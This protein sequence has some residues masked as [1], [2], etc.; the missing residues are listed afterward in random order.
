MIRL[1]KLRYYILAFAG[2]VSQFI[3]NLLNPQKSWDSSA[4]K[5]LIF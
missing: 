5:V 1:L 3:A 2:I 4:S